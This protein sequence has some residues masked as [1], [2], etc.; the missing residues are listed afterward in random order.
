MTTLF[1]Y[2][3]TCCNNCLVYSYNLIIL[4]IFVEITLL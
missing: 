4:T 2:R 3:Y 1:L